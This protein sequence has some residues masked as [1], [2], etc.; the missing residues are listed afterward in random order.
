MVVEARGTV[1]RPIIEL[2][3]EVQQSSVPSSLS[4][5]SSSAPSPR[6]FPLPP[7]PTRALLSAL[8]VV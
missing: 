1:G 6:S 7:H 5:P 2:I 8:F 4:P 3:I